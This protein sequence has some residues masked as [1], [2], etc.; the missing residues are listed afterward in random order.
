[1]TD[2]LMIHTPDGG[3]ICL[4]DNEVRTGDDPVRVA[5]IVTTT[6]PETACYLSLFGGNR[7]DSGSEGNRFTWWG[8][9][10]EE[11]P[12]ARYISEFQSTLR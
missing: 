11:D 1:M 3:E 12:N 6:T 8:N 2:V 10:G 9:L 5:D 7:E 4:T